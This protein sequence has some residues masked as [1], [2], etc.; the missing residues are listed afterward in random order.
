MLDYGWCAEP[1]WANNAH[2]K[3]TGD[4]AIVLI[5]SS[6]STVDETLVWCQVNN[7]AVGLLGSLQWDLVNTQQ[8]NS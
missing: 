6:I 1:N 7:F 3:A 4:Q 5:Q 8:S 2:T